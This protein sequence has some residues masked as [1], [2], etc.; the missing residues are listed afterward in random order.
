MKFLFSRW[1]PL[2]PIL[3][4]LLVIV[5]ACYFEANMQVIADNLQ[6]MQI[7]VNN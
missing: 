3:N 7:S 5:F 1:V 4:P 6:V 2:V